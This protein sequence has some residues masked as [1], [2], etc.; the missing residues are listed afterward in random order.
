LDSATGL[1]NRNP[2][3]SIRYLSQDIGL[4][5]NQKR[6]QIPLTN[7]DS[8]MM[9]PEIGA[10]MPFRYVEVENLPEPLTDATLERGKSQYPFDDDAGTFECSDPK[11]N[12]IWDICHYSMKALTFCGQYVDG[13]RERLPY[14]ADSYIHMLGHYACDREFTLARYSQEHLITHPT[15]PT[16]WPMHSVM[17]SWADYMY[18]GDN[19]SLVEF[20]DD[21]KA[22]TLIALARPDGLISTVEPKPAPST[23]AAIYEKSLRDIVDWPQHERD[24]YDMRPVN[25]V[26]NCFH[27]HACRLMAQI[28]SV[29]GNTADAALFEKR[30][31]DVALA[32]NDKLFDTAR[33]LYVDGEGSAHASLHANMMPAAFG[34]IPSQRK[35]TVASFLQGK[36]MD[37]S[38]YGA[39]YF[40]EALFELGLDR[41][42]LDLATA[43]GDRS[44]WHMV[45]DVGTT[46]TLEAWDNKYKPNQDWNHAWG[47]A[48]ANLLPRKLMGIEPTSPGFATL[49]VK[50]RPGGLSWASIKLPTI[51]GAVHAS[52]KETADLFVLDIETPANTRADIHLPLLSHNQPPKAVVDG[53]PQ[54]A[55]IADGFAVISNVG[56]G[57][58]HIELT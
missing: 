56:S 17:M 26:V 1:V 21:I 58:H 18:T 46:I 34:L 6:Y 33:G 49:R 14:E 50:P 54:S 36:A 41:H 22:K 11:I 15:W 47:A 19:R 55:A 9:P 43:D 31:N 16:E 8:R 32:I 48:P 10:V 44:W 28:A 23:L 39:Q 52:F 5:P 3:G 24:S 13:D 38:V 29:L 57:K 35:G 40:M 20:Y 2:G 53:N 27:A 45:N 4:Q 7:A 42:A 37:C 30:A 51:R 12:A 25:T